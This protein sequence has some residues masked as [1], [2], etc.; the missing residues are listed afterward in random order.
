M[1]N[2]RP[3]DGRPRNRCPECHSANIY[4][5][6][7]ASKWTKNSRKRR[8]YVIDTGESDGELKK[9]RCIDCKNEFDIAL[10]E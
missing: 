7:L 6:S 10:V 9:Y 4:K 8:K 2:R 1:I 5:R 3:R